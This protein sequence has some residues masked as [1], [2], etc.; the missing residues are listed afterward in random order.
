M[1]MP[2]IASPGDSATSWQ[3]VPGRPEQLQT[4]P[5]GQSRLVMQWTMQ[6]MA[7]PEDDR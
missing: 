4:I 1:Q 5:A 6:A 3:S 2:S 7:A